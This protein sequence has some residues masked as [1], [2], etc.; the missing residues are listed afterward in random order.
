MSRRPSFPDFIEEELLRVPM[1]L[2]AVIDAV[3]ERWR[4]RLP[5][6]SP[7]DADPARALRQ[8]SAELITQTLRS[9]RES[10]QADLRN[11]FSKAASKGRLRGSRC[12]PR[13]RARTKR[14]GPKGLVSRATFRSWTSAEV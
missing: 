12:T 8:H 3:Q 7:G 14:S 11:D 10:A 13:H 2:D 1:T 9:L 4:L 5:Q 6:H